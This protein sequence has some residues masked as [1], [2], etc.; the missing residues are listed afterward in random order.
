MEKIKELDGLR[1][2]A[3]LLV[4]AWHYIGVADGPN[5][6]LW[7]VFYLGHF[8]VDLFFVLS[9]FLITTVLLEN[10]SSPSY[11]S[12]FYGRRAFRI[13]PLYYLMVLLGLL[14]RWSGVHPPLFNSA[15][16]AWAYL[17]G[18]Q[19]FWM[20]RLQSYGMPWL[21][22]T[23]SL[24]IEEQ[25]YLFFPLLVRFVSMSVLWKILLVIIV[26]CPIARLLD[27]FTSDEFG[28]YVLPQFRADALAIGALIALYRFR[29]T[30]NVTVRTF[31]RWTL[32]GAACL[33][34]LIIVSGSTT[35]HAAAWQHTLAELFFGAM[36]FMVLENQGASCLAV[37]RS[38]VAAHLARW[39][40]A[41]YLIH[42]LVVYLVFLALSLPRT[43]T[44][45]PGI[46][47]TGLALTIT[48]LLCA[49]SYRFLE[50]PL[51]QYASSQYSFRAKIE[52]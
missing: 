31:V 1:A 11:F 18:I 35:F 52:A 7:R 25:F 30:A 51:I 14:G 41:S 24:A 29:G 5:F 33:V 40:Y 22:G 19:N 46:A 21:G 2:T 8:G 34:P 17:L 3:A 32:I 49:V 6:W 50:K 4:I 48:L 23:W 20:A 38:D 16:P 9:G 47:A 37:L 43:V 13:W 36:I 26:S 44:T 39:S 28:Y 45:L 15:V 12:S 10:R 27:S 42:P